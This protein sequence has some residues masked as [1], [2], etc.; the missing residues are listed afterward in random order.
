MPTC[1]VY[2]DSKITNS[3]DIPCGCNANSTYSVINNYGRPNRTRYEHTCVC[4][5]GYL[6]Q[7]NWW[8]KDSC[9][10]PT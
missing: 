6:K 10:K 9:V 7:N 5:P 2:P 4:D 8:T 1:P 3:K